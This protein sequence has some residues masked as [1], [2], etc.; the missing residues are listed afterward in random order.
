VLETIKLVDLV[1][2]ERLVFKVKLIRHLRGDVVELR[3]IS[4]HI[5]IY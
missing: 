5:F 3:E 4:C 2:V 1:D